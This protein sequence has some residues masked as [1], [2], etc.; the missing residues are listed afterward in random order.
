M[1]SKPFNEY[2]SFDATPLFVNATKLK[3]QGHLLWGDGV[4]RLGPTQNGRVEVKAR[5]KSGW[6]MENA[7][8]GKSLL[9]LYFIDVGQG[10]GV[11]IQAP[12]FRHIMIDGGNPG[13]SR[14]QERT[15]PTSSIGNL[16][17]TTAGG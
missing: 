12:D 13:K 16:S 5:G 9:E 8:G 3:K 4:R 2:V 15:R 7:L 14:T 1:K 6:V 11:L 17:R 10:D